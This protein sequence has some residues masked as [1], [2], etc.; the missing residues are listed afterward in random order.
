MAG[1]SRGSVA[2]V[3]PA[4]RA[5]MAR[6]LDGDACA[7]EDMLQQL[8]GLLRAYFR[9]R[10]QRDGE[11]EDLVQETLLAVHEK[12]HTYDR[13]RLLTPWVFA[14]ARFKLA[15]LRRTQVRRP[16]TALDEAVAVGEPGDQDE[17]AVRLDLSRLLAVLPARQRRLLV[18]V[19]LRGESVAHIAEAEGMSE[20]AVKVS[21]HRGLRTLM[22]RVRDDED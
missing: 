14:I 4:L 21:V 6:A 1:P 5:L 22:M 12:R 10:V 17:A 13:A 8:S 3:E 11:A 15:G 7:Y 16:T 2:V 9:R 19:K 18:G 20:G